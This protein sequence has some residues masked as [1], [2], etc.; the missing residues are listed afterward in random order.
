MK[1]LEE[2]KEK[3]TDLQYRLVT[4]KTFNILSIVNTK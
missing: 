3:I 1:E 2:V 4:L